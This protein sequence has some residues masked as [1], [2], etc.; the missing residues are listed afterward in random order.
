LIFNEAQITQIT[1]ILPNLCKLWRKWQI[2]LDP[3]QGLLHTLATSYLLSRV[4]GDCACP[5]S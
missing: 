5:L 1:R 2:Y 4:N 3:L